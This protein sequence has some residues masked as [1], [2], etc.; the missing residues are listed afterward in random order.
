MEPGW[1]P[2]PGLPRVITARASVQATLAT[3]SP[4]NRLRTRK[5]AADRRVGA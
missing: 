2:K 5:P 3:L 1:A 4:G